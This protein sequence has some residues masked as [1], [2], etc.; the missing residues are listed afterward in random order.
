MLPTLRGPGRHALTVVLSLLAGA[1]LFAL[2]GT[3]ARLRAVEGHVRAAIELREAFPADLR[4][5]L[6]RGGPI[7]VRVEAALWEDRALWDR[8]VEAPRVTVFR[9]SRQPNGQAIAV[10]DAGGGTVL[11]PP[12]PNPLTVDVDLGAVDR[13]ASNSRYYVDGV[14]TIGTLG[15]E[16]ADEADEVFGRDTGSAGLKSVGKFLLN[17]VLQLSDYVRSVS[18]DIRSRRITGAEL[19]R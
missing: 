5:V 18:A 1:E 3:V 17:T 2:E 8:V 14:V 16:E 9:I 19:K 4:D 6:E 11:Y 13:V 10:V 15:E 12:Y 7:H